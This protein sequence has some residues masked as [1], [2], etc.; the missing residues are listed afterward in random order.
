MSNLFPEPFDDLA[1]LASEWALTSEE[2]R[3]HKRVSTDIEALRGLY[4][5]VYPRLD[6]ILAYLAALGDVAPESMTPQDRRLLDFATTVMEASIPFD[7]DWPDNDIE[8][9]F[10]PTRF[11]FIGSSKKEA[12]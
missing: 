6:A 2:M 12:R 11:E 5:T 8:D 9:A 7:L 3:F 4:M 1:P 10:S